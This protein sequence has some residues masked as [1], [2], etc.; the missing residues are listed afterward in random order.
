M[1]ELLIPTPGEEIKNSKDIIFSILTERQPLSAIQ[2][3]NIT[4]KKYNTNLTYQAINKT[5]T[6]LIA[7]GILEKK[8]KNYNINQKWLTEVK[9]LVDR[10]L[11]GNKSEK[12][13]IKFNEDLAQKDYAIYTFTNLLDLDS[14]WDDM[15]MYLANKI[16]PEENKSFIAHAHYGW[17]LLINLGKETKMFNY[18]LK[19]KIK[20][21]NLFIGDYPLNKWAKKI[22]E[23][24]G[25]KFKIIKDKTINE[26][27]TLNVIG[28]TVIQVHYPDK[29]IN[30]LR[31]FYTK[32][33]NTQE[34][35]MKEISE[36][37][38]EHCDLKFVMFKNRD[39]A[40]SLREKYLKKFKQYL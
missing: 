38:H 8:E 33:K 32:Y 17:W 16:G 10:L 1:I 25:V 37:A 30:K 24:L 6:Q 26:K 11:T 39:I 3:Y 21:Y 18:L 15:L 12:Q 36:L 23:D 28:D 35:S 4:R 13:I 7:K 2:I 31:E 27:I 20:C 14:F 9:I 19:K 22:Y 29:T 5:L 40:D 34:M